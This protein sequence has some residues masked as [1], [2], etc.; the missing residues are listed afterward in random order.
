[1]THP[2]RFRNKVMIVTGAQTRAMASRK[3]ILEI[4][5]SMALPHVAGEERGGSQVS[6]V[7]PLS[8]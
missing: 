4:C 5:R 7:Q 3:S 8:S 6:P 1:M 2:N